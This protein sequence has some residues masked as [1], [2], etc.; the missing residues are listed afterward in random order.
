MHHTY[1]VVSVWGVVGAVEID[2]I[3]Y[4][5]IIRGLRVEMTVVLLLVFASRR[6]IANNAAWLSFLAEVRRLL[7]DVYSSN[8]S[9][10]IAK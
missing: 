9:L 6:L 1:V 4:N 2:I 8:L 10:I 5:I 3:Y 7:C